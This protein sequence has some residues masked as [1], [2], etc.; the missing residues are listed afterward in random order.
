MTIIGGLYHCKPQKRHRQELSF[1][2]N[3]VLNSLH[4][5]VTTTTFEEQILL[6]VSTPFKHSFCFP[7]LG[8]SSAETS[9]TGY[10]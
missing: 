7:L 8:D 9:F 2:V 3:K 1:R 10:H 5:V 6:S 4:K